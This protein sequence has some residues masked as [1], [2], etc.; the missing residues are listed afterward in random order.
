MAETRLCDDD[1]GGM[2]GWGVCERKTDKKERARHAYHQRFA[3][4]LKKWT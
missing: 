1:K 3:Q 2:R 4:R